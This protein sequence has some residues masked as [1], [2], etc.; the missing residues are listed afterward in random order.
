MDNE[1]NS[2]SKL[3][4]TNTQFFDTN[5]A[6]HTKL[7]A[8]SNN[9]NSINLQNNRNNDS[10]LSYSRKEFTDRKNTD[11][12]NMSQS[13]LSPEIRSSQ[14]N[15][16][17]TYR[18]DL[19]NMQIINEPKTYDNQHE[20]ESIYFSSNR[21]LMSS[22]EFQFENKIKKNSDKFTNS[23]N[24]SNNNIEN[25]KERIKSLEKENM[26]S[27]IENRPDKLVIKILK[28]NCLKA[29]QKSSI[30]ESNYN[31]PNDVNSNYT[32]RSTLHNESKSNFNSIN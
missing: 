30:N 31:N 17:S 19:K 18:S 6:K 9:N 15:N 16:D 1:L 8:K 12:L 13:P 2:A 5:L 20:S 10:N 21:N 29:S 24:L 4:Q 32:K 26:I 23:Y 14:R 25:L 3:S 22:N 11:S 28:N 7:I 27:V